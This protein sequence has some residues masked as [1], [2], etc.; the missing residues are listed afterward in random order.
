[1]QG[2]QRRLQEAKSQF[3]Q[4]VDAALKEEPQHEN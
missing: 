2:S 4:A 3:S 1:M